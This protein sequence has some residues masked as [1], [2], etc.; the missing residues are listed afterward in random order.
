MNNFTAYIIASWYFMS[1]GHLAFGILSL[2][3]SML[4]IGEI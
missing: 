4:Y 2:C 1:T 3:V